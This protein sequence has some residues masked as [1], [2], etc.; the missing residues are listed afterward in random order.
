MVT[1]LR[2]YLKKITALFIILAAIFFVQI[3]FAQVKFSVVCP[4]KK[5]GKNDLLQIQFRVE[6][7]ANVDNITPPS[8]NNFT[9]VSGPNQ[10][11]SVTSING[12]ISQSVSIGFSLKPLS[13]GK[14]T[15]GPATAVADG[16]DYKTNPITI[17]VVDGSVV[18]QNSGNQN[19]SPFPSLNFDFPPAPV[20]H[21]FDDYILK[22]G[23]NVAEKIKKN[24]F[25]KLDVDKKSCY[26]GEPVV[27]TYKLYTRLPSETTV[28]DAPSF[29]GFSVSDIDVSNNAVLQKYNGRMYNVYTMRKVQLYPLQAG[30]ITLDPV[31]ADN[32]ITFIKSQYANSRSDGFFDMF[33]NL[34]QA[35]LPPE[36]Q[37]DQNVTLKS[38]PVTITVKPLPSENKPADFR[39]AVGDFT[40]SASLEKNQIT[41]D[42]AGILKLTVSGKGNIQLINAPSITWPKGIDGYDAKVKDNVDKTK[43]PMQ[44]SKVFSFPFTVSKAG[45][46]TIDSISF[47]YFDPQISLYKTLHTAPLEIEVR[48]G[49]G[50][51]NALAKNVQQN[52]ADDFFTKRTEFI[53]GIA[54]VIGII[55]LT[56]FL[57]IKKNRS[58][59]DLESEI[60]LDDLKNET[61]EEAVEFKIPESPL[62]EVHKKLV[63][64]DSKEFYHTLD[65]SL[66]RYL[67]S[68]FQIPGNELSKKRLTEELDKCN[69]SLNTSLMLTS[70]MDEIELNLYAPPSTVNVMN[71]VF[72][73]ASE[74]VSLL[75]KQVC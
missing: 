8:F 38:T 35:S 23:E 58:K 37:I 43:V 10:Q 16:T 72:E 53:A 44:G 29:N 1:F 24:I 60:K 5:I 14:F 61:S 50:V 34:G 26:V 3:S 18:Q 4:D 71:Q 68:K 75:D 22:P 54:F 21:Q 57:I 31:V 19:S 12:K 63:E 33:D 40:I 20:T 49:K 15:I 41:T 73:K 42:D 65:T 56:I 70:L 17:E 55:F 27:A 32:K 25:L 13:T 6:G 74:V 2:S 7:S 36:A 46:Y 48:K 69:V 47:S 45:K 28:T 66:K 30:D 51:P 67:S 39:G 64:Q 11:R 52:H 59:N 62:T 9:I